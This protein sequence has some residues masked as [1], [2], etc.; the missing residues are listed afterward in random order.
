MTLFLTASSFYSIFTQV[1]TT[2]NSTVALQVG[3]L[4]HLGDVAT[5]LL[6]LRGSHTA[7]F[8]P[9]TSIHMHAVESDRK[10]KP[11]RKVSHFAAFQSS[12]LVNSGLRIHIT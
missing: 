2:F 3:F 7:L 9:L 8:V 11:V 4:K 5:V 12:N 10:S 6:D 1:P